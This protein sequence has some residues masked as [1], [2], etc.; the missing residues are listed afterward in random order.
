MKK[1]KQSSHLIDIVIDRKLQYIL[2]KIGRKSEA[3]FVSCAI[4]F[5]G[6]FLWSR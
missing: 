6:K 4:W 2:K 1:S 5:G 3:E